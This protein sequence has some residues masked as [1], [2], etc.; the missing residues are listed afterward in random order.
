MKTKRSAKTAS[1]K[2]NTINAIMY[3]ALESLFG[4]SSE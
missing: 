4:V 3:V 1:I 2:N